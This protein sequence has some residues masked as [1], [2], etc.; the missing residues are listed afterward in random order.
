MAFMKTSY[1]LTHSKT[2]PL[3]DVLPKVGEEQNNLIWDGM[4]WVPKSEWNSRE[5]R[6]NVDG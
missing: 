1:P 2:I 3:S 5:S 4:N 6:E